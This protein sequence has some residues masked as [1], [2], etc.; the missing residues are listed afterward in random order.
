MSTNRTDADE[1][2]SP[3]GPDN[4]GPS[5]PGS[6][7]GPVVIRH[8]LAYPLPL[9]TNWVARDIVG[10]HFVSYIAGRTLSCFKEIAE[11]HAAPTAD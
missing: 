7:I 9:L 1:R 5:G 8:D 2:R 11:R 3:N 4:G 6:N 10:G